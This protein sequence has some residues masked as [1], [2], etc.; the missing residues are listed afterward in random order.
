MKWST[1]GDVTRL[2]MSVIGNKNNYVGS[3][4]GKNKYDI[5]FE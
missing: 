4:N 5:Q 1:P 3:E 2:F